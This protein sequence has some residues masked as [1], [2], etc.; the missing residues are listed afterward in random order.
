MLF[1]SYISKVYES[2][3][4]ENVCQIH[5]LHSNQQNICSRFRLLHFF[6]PGCLLLISGLYFRWLKMK[7]EVINSS[8]VTIITGIRKNWAAGKEYM[9]MSVHLP[10][11]K[12]EKHT[13][14]TSLDLLR[15]LR[16]HYT[17]QESC[18]SFNKRIYSFNKCE[19]SI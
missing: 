3:H 16:Y 9:L 15:D 17:K 1:T 5:P 19:C 18:Q 6:A 12:L 2:V 8:C 10:F 13:N 11:I 7:N 14:L 4:N